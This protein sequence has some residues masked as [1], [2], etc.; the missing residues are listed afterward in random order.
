MPATKAPETR[1]D[2]ASVWKNAIHAVFWN[3]T[4]KMSVSTARPVTGS[5]TFGAEEVIRRQTGYQSHGLT[6]KSADE[7]LADRD[8]IESHNS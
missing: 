3:R 1:K 6:A 5:I 2:A 4:A 7:Y 8:K